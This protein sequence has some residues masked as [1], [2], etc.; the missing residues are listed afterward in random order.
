[1]GVEG[2]G[3]WGLFRVRVVVV[4]VKVGRVEV[5]NMYHVSC[6]TIIDTIVLNNYTKNAYY[7]DTGWGGGGSPGAS[8]K[9]SRSLSNRYIL[10]LILILIIL[11]LLLII[12]IIIIIL[13]IILLLIILP[14][15][16]LLII[17]IPLIYY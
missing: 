6:I 8:G 2:V 11:L 14:L 16:I 4:G 7:N 5:G 3:V 15:I 12:I 9:L 17:I 1:V 10:I 13:L